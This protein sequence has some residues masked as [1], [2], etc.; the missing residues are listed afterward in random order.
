M[1]SITF[2]LSDLDGYRV[3]LATDAD[4]SSPG[5]PL[6]PAESL[7]A[8]LLERAASCG[9]TVFHSPTLIPL[10]PFA[11]DIIS[12]EGCGFAVPEEVRLRA[13]RALGPRMGQLVPQ[14]SR[15][16]A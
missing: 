15:S 10:V 1:A 6:T 5:R 2:T 9:A 3:E 7:A 4:A 11:L 16:K 12:P 13:R 14:V 8:S